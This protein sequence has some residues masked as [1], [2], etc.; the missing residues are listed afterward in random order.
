[1]PIIAPVFRPQIPA[2]DARLAFEIA[3][4]IRGFALQLDAAWRRLGSRPPFVSRRRP[5]AIPPAPYRRGKLQ[6]TGP[7]RQFWKDGGK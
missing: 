7:A 2:G 6:T 5:C 1:V 4:R 3:N